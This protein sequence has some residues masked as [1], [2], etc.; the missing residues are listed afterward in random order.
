VAKVKKYTSEQ[1]L[2]WKTFEFRKRLADRFD[3]CPWPPSV[4]AIV[5]AACSSGTKAERIIEGA[6]KLRG[7]T[8]DEIML[9]MSCF[10]QKDWENPEVQKLISKKI[11]SLA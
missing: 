3:G 10:E 2:K 6:K 1:W 5:L 9:L 8:N 7:L 4:L 11:K